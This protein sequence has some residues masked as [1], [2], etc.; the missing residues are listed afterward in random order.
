MHMPCLSTLFVSCEKVAE[1]LSRPATKAF[2][3]D[4]LLESLVTNLSATCLRACNGVGSC[5][6]CSL[7]H[8]NSPCT[9]FRHISP[10][11]SCNTENRCTPD[12]S[13]PLAGRIT[14]VFRPLVSHTRPHQGF[15]LLAS[16]HNFTACLKGTCVSSV[17]LSLIRRRDTA[18]HP[19]HQLSQ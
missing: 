11:Q 19:L 2:R 17:L 9:H 16:T 7:P 10:L 5:L 6:R 4:V 3:G 12:P 8:C 15:R 14:Q 13:F 18:P 1:T